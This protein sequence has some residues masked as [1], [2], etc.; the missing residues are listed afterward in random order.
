MNISQLPMKTCTQHITGDKGRP[1]G[2]QEQRWGWREKRHICR[3]AVFSSV[4]RHEKLVLWETRLWQ[5]EKKKMEE[6]TTQRHDKTEKSHI[7]QALLWSTC[8]CLTSYWTFQK[9]LK[10][11][12]V[13]MNEGELQPGGFKM[14][15]QHAL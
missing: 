12:E 5:K 10:E 4:G 3:A 6:C 15:S 2:R 9:K 14:R 11:T 13:E 7:R 8:P 1:G